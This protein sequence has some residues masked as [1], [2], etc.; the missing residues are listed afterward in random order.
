MDMYLYTGEVLLSTLRIN[1]LLRPSLASCYYSYTKRTS[2]GV[3]SGVNTGW[4]LL[5]LMD[6][7]SM[8]ILMDNCLDLLFQVMWQKKRWPPACIL[9]ADTMCNEQ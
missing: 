7:K 3:R 4:N 5:P 6:Y 9:E 2:N 8:D 1:V